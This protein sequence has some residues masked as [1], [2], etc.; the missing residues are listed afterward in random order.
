MGQTR[1]LH[2]L[3]PSFTRGE[4]RAGGQPRVLRLPHFDIHSFLFFVR[5]LSLSKSWNPQRQCP[6]SRGRGAACLPSSPLP[7]PF[8]SP[9]LFFSVS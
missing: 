1:F 7:L 6:V 9:L 5:F 8:P 2:R 3:N 4:T